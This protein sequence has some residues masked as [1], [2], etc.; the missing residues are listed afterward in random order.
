MH[1][2]TRIGL[3][4]AIVILGVAGA[5]CFRHEPA[6]PPETPA[7]SLA[8]VNE[9]LEQ[10]PTRPYLPSK[11][12]TPSEKS[13]TD[14]YARLEKSQRTPRKPANSEPGIDPTPSPIIARQ[15]QAKTGK[16]ETNKAGSQQHPAGAIA[17]KQPDSQSTNEETVSTGPRLHTV[18]RGETLSEIAHK[19]LGSSAR[20][21]DIY[22]INQDQLR[23]PD[24]LQLGMVLKI[25]ERNAPSLTQRLAQAEPPAETTAEQT[26]KQ[27]SEASNKNATPPDPAANK[28]SPRKPN[29]SEDETK[30]VNNSPRKLFVP[31]NRFPLSPRN[32]QT[33]PTQIS[34]KESEETRE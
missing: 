22:L 6:R 3:A 19:Y 13:S 32:E 26:K 5:F 11:Q 33:P 2:E 25:P 17:S 10:R 21:Q 23:S 30:S 8:D 29:S 1:S 7:L 12:A 9:Q 18:K 28:N 20:F 14:E 34:R 24:A 16:T 4:M 27:P 15:D 31:V